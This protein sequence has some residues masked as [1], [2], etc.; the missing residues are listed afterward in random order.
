M[1][2]CY[3]NELA[4][5]LQNFPTRIQQRF[6]GLIAWQQAQFALALVNIEKVFLEI[7]RNGKATAQQCR[8]ATREYVRINLFHLDFYF[9]VAG[10]AIM[11]FATRSFSDQNIDYGPW[12]PLVISLAAILAGIIPVIVSMLLYP[13]HLI[14]RVNIW[15]LTLLNALISANIFA[16]VEPIIPNYFYREGVLSYKDLIFGILVFYMIALLYLQLRLNKY[17]CLNCYW[18]RHKSQDINSLMPADKRGD[19]M[20]IYAQDHYVNITTNK[21]EHLHRMSMKEAVAM[22]PENTGLQVHRS[23]WVA[24]SA[25]LTLQKQSDK[26]QLELR[27]GTKIPVSRTK[28]AELK[29]QLSHD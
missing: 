21:G 13:F 27:N 20:A 22:I 15:L 18:D 3:Y 25:M 19:I 6:R 11:V 28:I 26:Y 8:S 5:E 10:M 9:I 7:H 24:F 1:L 12:R 17:I 14:M 4:A 16:F 2:Y 29:L 23:H